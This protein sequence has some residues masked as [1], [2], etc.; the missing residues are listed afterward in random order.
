[1]GRN[2]SRNQGTRIPSCLLDEKFRHFLLDFAIKK[3]G[4]KYSLA[5]KLGY[6]SVGSGKTVNEWYDGYAKIPFEKLQ[7]L[8]FIVGIPIEEVLS[9]QVKEKVR[10]RI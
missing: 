5:M 6:V 7:K 9:H 2:E 8:S 1:M 4:S 10:P 3:E